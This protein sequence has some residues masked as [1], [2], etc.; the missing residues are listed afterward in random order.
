MFGFAVSRTPQ[1]ALFVVDGPPA[2]TAKC[3]RCGE[4]L[5]RVPSG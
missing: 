1:P 3:Q 5:E 2:L 4:Y